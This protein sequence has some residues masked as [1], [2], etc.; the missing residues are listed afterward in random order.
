MSDQLTADTALK[1]KATIEAEALVKRHR[2]GSGW[3]FWIAGLSLVNS[4]VILAGSDWSFLIGLGVTQIIDAIAL[5]LAEESGATGFSIFT[6]IA[7]LLDV[8][9]AG[10]FVLWGV[11]ARMGQRWAYVVGMVLYILDGLIFL[12][13]MDLPSI[14]FHLFA[15][16][17]IFTGFKASGQLK[18][19]ESLVAAVED[20]PGTEA[21]PLPLAGPS[22]ED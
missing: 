15:L 5:A 14:G 18:K 9:V 20:G 7:F 10:S 3:F 12:L 19:L 21:P 22:G 1:E 6:V 4:V 17:F 11:L 13:V 8:L 16:F 2:D